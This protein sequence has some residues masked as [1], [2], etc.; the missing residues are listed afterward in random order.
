MAIA[1]CVDIRI[2]ADTSEF[3]IPAARLG[4]GYP[5]SLTHSLVRIM[6]AGQSS[7]LL[8]TGRRYSAEEALMAGF[9]NRVVPAAALEQAT[10]AIAKTIAS[11]A[12]LSVRAAKAAI[13]S[14]HSPKYVNAAESLVSSCAESTDSREGQNA[15]ME[16]RRPQFMGS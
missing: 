4:I 10:L 16:K 7:E 14:T 1:T 8:F 12:P 9:A 5:V 11:N 15:F 2:C 6:G 13:R 3:A